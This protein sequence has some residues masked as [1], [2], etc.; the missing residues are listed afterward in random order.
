MPFTIEE[1]IQDAFQEAQIIPKA[2]AAIKAYTATPKAD[3]KYAG[4]CPVLG[5]DPAGLLGVQLAMIDT[6]EEQAAN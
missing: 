5:I 1:G 3:R 6:V 2:I 4:L